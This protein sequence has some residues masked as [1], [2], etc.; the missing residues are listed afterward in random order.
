[1]RKTLVT[2]DLTETPKWAVTIDREPIAKLSPTTDA[3]GVAD[4]LDRL[5][6]ISGVPVA[7]TTVREPDDYQYF[8]RVQIAHE[9][10]ASLSGGMKQQHSGRS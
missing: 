8:N 9:T 1:M 5:G 10:E 7:G 3:D 6:R 4:L 2:D